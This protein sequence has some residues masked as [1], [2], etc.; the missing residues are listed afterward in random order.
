MTTKNTYWAHNGRYQKFVPQL[1]ALVPYEGS[2]EKPHKNKMLEKF[3]KASNCYYDLYNNGL[4]NRAREFA[5]IFGIRS[6]DYK[7]QKRTWNGRIWVKH[8]VF[9]DTI[10]RDLEP[11]MD[12]IVLAAAEEQKI[13]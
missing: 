5:R 1:E 6:S 9:S 2:V 13:I 12:Q 4:C 3:R 7:Y 11:R 10:Y 8:S